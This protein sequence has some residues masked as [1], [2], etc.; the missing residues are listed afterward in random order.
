MDAVAHYYDGIT[1]RA[2]DAAVN[3]GY[4]RTIEVTLA[5]DKF[6][7]P[8]EHPELKWQRTNKGVRIQYGE[9][10]RMVLVIHDPDLA[11]S[12]VSELKRAGQ[13][14]THDS[15]LQIV[16]K[17]PLLVALVL[18]AAAVL[19]YFFV[20]PKMAENL[21]KVMPVSADENLGDMVWVNLKHE[22]DIDHERSAVLQEFADKIDLSEDYDLKM[23]VVDDPVV[24]AFALPG[25]YI[26][27]YAGIMDR[28]G[29][30]EELAALLA[31]ESVHVDE[32]HSTRQLMRDIAGYAFLSL[33]LGDVNSVLIIAAEHGDQ[34][35]AMAYSR[36][37]EMEADAA[38]MEAMH[39]NGIDPAGMVE[40]MRI[41]EDATSDLPEEISFLSTHPLTSERI[42]H[43]ERKIEDLGELNI[44]SPDLEMLFIQIKEDRIQQFVD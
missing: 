41:L 22:L 11:N 24:N 14:D 6:V 43:A 12:V 13:R 8:L 25:G 1:S 39:R 26:V 19:G 30:P 33:L 40:L 7:W 15:L 38:G 27:V 36:S 37:L 9:H 31:H 3:M 18:T 17:A 10:P 5:R 42:E 21:A 16:G 44:S 23:F 34:L 4:D 20:L 28:M 2:H 32:R 29:N 35:R